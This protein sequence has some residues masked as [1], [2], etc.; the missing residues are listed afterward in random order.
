MNDFKKNNRFGDKRGGGFNKGAFRPSFGGG[1]GGGKSFGNG[2]PP[3]EMFSATCASCN[4]MC[5]VPFKPNGKKSVYCKD[6]FAANGGPAHREGSNDRGGERFAPRRDFDRPRPFKPEFRS[7]TGGGIG[8]LKRTIETMSSKLDKLVL[9]M[10]VQTPIVEVSTIKK[11]EKKTDTKK[12]VSK[13]K[14]K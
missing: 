10:S 1:N 11:T 2:R 4:K 3:L 9:L 6:C 13:K 14:S 7:E 12:K 8:E 5:E